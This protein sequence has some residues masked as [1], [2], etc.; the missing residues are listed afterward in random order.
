MG[1][2][3]IQL[4]RTMIIRGRRISWLAAASAALVLSCVVQAG[5]GLYP[6]HTTLYYAFGVEV[7]WL[8]WFA[9]F[10]GSLGGLCGSLVFIV[11]C[12][13][14]RAICS[15]RRHRRQERG[16]CTTCG[17]DLRAS[18]ERCPEC[19]NI[20]AQDDRDRDAVR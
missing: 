11:V 1:V 10:I 4:V 7:P 18:G 19:G 5:I 12:L 3:P 14:H 20:R 15:W 2:V 16:L 17:Y 9:L 13:V 8:V 6:G